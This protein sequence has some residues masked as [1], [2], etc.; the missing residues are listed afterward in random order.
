MPD[1]RALPTPG[2]MVRLDACRESRP[3]ERSPHHR[4]IED[5]GGASARVPVD[6]CDGGQSLA[7]SQ[8]VGKVRVQDGLA[9]GQARPLGSLPWMRSVRCVAKTVLG[10]WLQ[11]LGQGVDRGGQ[12]PAR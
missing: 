2:A 6:W 7:I 9:T 3:T 4:P 1:R 12:V 5:R 10:M 8:G 11:K